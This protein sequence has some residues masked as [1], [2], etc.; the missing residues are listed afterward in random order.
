M[1]VAFFGSGAFA[2]ATLSR[3]H[4]RGSIVRV[5]SQP[6]RP[7]GRKRVLTPTPV[8]AYALEHGLDLDRIEDVNATE[9]T[10]H[11]RDLDVD[12]WVVIA[13]GQKLSSQLL[14]DR[15]AVNLH[16]SLL[17]RWRGAAPIHHAILAGD[18]HTG[19]SVITLANVMD[20]GLVLGSR[21]IPIGHTD[22]TADVHDA[23][24]A[25][26]PDL[27]DEVLASLLCGAQEGTPQDAA[28]VTTAPKL[29]RA[30]AQLDLNASADVLR[31]RINALSPW[32]G[33]RLR[34]DG[35]ELRL[36]RA[37]SS[38]GELPLGKMTSAGLVGTGEGLLE[39]LQV[40]PAGGR[41]MD[42]GQWLPGRRSA[43][44]LIVE[45]IG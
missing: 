32:P 16:G 31:R 35:V 37:A 41:V 2:L 7:A 12:A 33:C 17:P 11:L 40:Q 28:L 44:D 3:L 34:V 21:S 15:V 42:I 13:F 8:S 20:A 19:V 36:L 6:D 39:V 43:G 24:A 25:L 1:R 23:L 30:D 26:G 4:E 18:T 45:Q 14:E 38:A 5:I 9:A 27:I 22:T 10:S 29:T